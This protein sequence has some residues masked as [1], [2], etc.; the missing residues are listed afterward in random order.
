[1]PKYLIERDLPGARKLSAQ[2]LQDISQKSC[3]GV[4]EMN[5]KVQWN[6]SYVMGDK[7]YCEYIAVNKDLVREHAMK[8]CF[9]E[10]HISE[11]GSMN[12]PTSAE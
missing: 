2:E 9:S 11:I 10:C 1:M 4:Q 8:G 6:K 7:I 3:E 12:D 5:P